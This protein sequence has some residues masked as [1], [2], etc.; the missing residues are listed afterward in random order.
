MSIRNMTSVI[1]PVFFFLFHLKI[2]AI[3]VIII[4]KKGKLLEPP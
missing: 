2:L 4:F 1:S 3:N